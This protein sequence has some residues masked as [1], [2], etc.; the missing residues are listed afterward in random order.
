MQTCCYNPIDPDFDPQ[1]R[2][3]WAAWQW[4]WTWNMLGSLIQDPF[5]D[6]GGFMNYDPFSF[7]P[8]MMDNEQAR[9]DCCIDSSNCGAY[10]QIRLIDTC[11]KFGP[12]ANISKYETAVL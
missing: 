5:T 12:P 7:S 1:W 6:A 8:L 10:H 9:R 4:A 3:N 2:D 11:E